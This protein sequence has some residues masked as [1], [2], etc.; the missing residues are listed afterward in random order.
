[1]AFGGGVCG[2]Q[3]I[4]STAQAEYLGGAFDLKWRTVL[5]MISKS[6]YLWPTR[7]RVVPCAWA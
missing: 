5:F 7:R 4:T 1:M 6:V 3:D 2:Q